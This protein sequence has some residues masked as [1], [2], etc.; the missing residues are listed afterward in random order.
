MAARAQAASLYSDVFS[1]LQYIIW[2]RPVHS[3]CRG[4]PEVIVHGRY[5]VIC[6]LDGAWALH[7]AWPDAELHII[8]TAGHAATEPG[9]AAALVEAIQQMAARFA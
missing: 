7:K 6:P 4:I 8:P 5:D 1:I 2:L 9:V 3:P